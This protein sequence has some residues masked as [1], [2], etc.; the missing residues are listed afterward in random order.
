MNR[1]TFVQLGL[2]S[3]AFIGSECHGIPYPA[4]GNATAKMF[5]GLALDI[6]NYMKART[7]E[8]E[9]LYGD[10]PPLESAVT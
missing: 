8:W 2:A 9:R 3:S 4:G 6:Q 10:V 1:R 5:Q 7:P